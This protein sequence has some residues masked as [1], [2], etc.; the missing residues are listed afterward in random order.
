MTDWLDIE[1]PDGITEK[2][3]KMAHRSS[4]EAGYRSSR[5]KWTGSK[6]AFSLVWEGML[7][8]DKALLQ[9]FFDNYQG[10]V[11][12]WTH[13]ELA[14]THNCVF[15]DDDLEFRLVG[16]YKINSNPAAIWSVTVNI[17]EQQGAGV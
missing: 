4:S 16:A 2:K 7:S 15:L 14:T 8:S 11:F 6:K 12:V 17:E 10:S 3:I 1:L 5:S 9:A 13:P